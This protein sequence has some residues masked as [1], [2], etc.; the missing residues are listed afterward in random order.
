MLGYG[1]HQVLNGNLSLGS[2][3]AFNVYIAMLVWPLRMLGMIV[4]QAQRAVV[5]AERVDEVL[6]TDRWWRTRRTRWGFPPPARA[7]VGARGLSVRWHSRGALLLWGPNL[8]ARRLR[9]ARTAGRVGG[10]GGG[11]RVG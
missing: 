1:G 6:A 4:A 10:A 9:P 2:L 11:D 7:T 8:G 5:S 3:I